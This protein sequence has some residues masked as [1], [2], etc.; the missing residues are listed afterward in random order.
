MAVSSAYIQFPF[1]TPFKHSSEQHK[2][3]NFQDQRQR[4]IQPQGGKTCL[5]KPLIKCSYGKE[6]EEG[7]SIR[8]FKEGLSSEKV[9]KLA[10]SNQHFMNCP[11]RRGVQFLLI[12][13]A[14]FKCIFAD[15]KRFITFLMQHSI[16]CIVYMSKKTGM[17]EA[18]GTSYN[19]NRTQTSSSN[20]VATNCSL[21]LNHTHFLL[22]RLGLQ[23]GVASCQ[24]FL[25]LTKVRVCLTQVSFGHTQFKGISTQLNLYAIL[26]RTIYKWKRIFF[27]FVHLEKSSHEELRIK[28]TK[29][30]ENTKKKFYCQGNHLTIRIHCGGDFCSTFTVPCQACQCFKN[31]V[32]PNWEN[33]APCAQTQALAKCQADLGFVPRVA[34]NTICY[35]TK[36]LCDQEL[37]QMICL[38]LIWRKTIYFSYSSKSFISIEHYFQFPFPKVLHNHRLTQKLTGSIPFLFMEPIFPLVSPNL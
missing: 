31:G 8:K 7:L 23:G 6:E 17:G 14:D 4:Y 37:Q 25:A 24:A 20:T 2:T 1:N 30:S 3:Q 11:A 29:Y 15:G 18:P 22:C 19:S 9:C 35:Y 27:L 32:S 33:Q 16:S 5:S 12:F 36:V 13:T 10:R 34:C 38:L 28:R 21:D 26:K